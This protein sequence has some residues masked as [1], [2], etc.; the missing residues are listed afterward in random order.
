MSEALDDGGLGGAGGG[1]QP[2]EV[3][4]C[5]W[6]D[7]FRAGAEGQSAERADASVVR[8]VGASEF[9]EPGNW[10]DDLGSISPG[11]GAQPVAQLL[12]LGGC[13]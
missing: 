9:F 6:V 12:S 5:T 13:I 1:A 8:K 2:M 4:G 11:G 10:L 3:R 7:T